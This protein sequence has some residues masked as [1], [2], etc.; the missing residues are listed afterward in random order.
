MQRV[1]VIHGDEGGKRQRAADRDLGAV[2]LAD[3][4]RQ[5]RIGVDAIANIDCRVICRAPLQIQIEEDIEVSTREPDRRAAIDIVNAI[6][7]T[8]ELA[9]ARCICAVALERRDESK[10][11]VDNRNAVVAASE[12][13][14]GRRPCD[15]AA[16]VDRDVAANALAGLVGVAGQNARAAGIEPDRA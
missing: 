3:N 10:R 14:A 16:N 5:W 8:F 12:T 15:V 4:E 6:L 13:C 7:M 1:D 2:R 11:P 9:F